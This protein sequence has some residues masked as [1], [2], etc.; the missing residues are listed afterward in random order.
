TPFLKPSD[1]IRGGKVFWSETGETL[2]ITYGDLGERN[3]YTYKVDAK[4][5]SAKKIYQEK[6]YFRGHWRDITPVSLSDE[7]ILF[8]SDKDG[9]YHLYTMNA[10]NGR[11]VKKLTKGEIY[12]RDIVGL[13]DDWIYFMASYIYREN[14]PYLYALHRIKTNGTDQQQVTQ[15]GVG[16]EVTPSPDLSHFLVEEM[17]LNSPNA[18]YVINQNG[19]VLEALT[20]PSFI[21]SEPVIE[22]VSAVTRDRRN[23]VWAS[24]HKPTD[25]DPSKS[26]PV[27]HH[28]HGTV[29]FYWSS[30][31]GAQRR[32]D[33]RQRIADLGFIVIAAD[34]MG[35]V[36]RTRRFLEAAHA[37]GH[38]WGGTLYIILLAKEIAKQRP[39][40]NM[41]KVGVH[42]LSQGGNCASRAIFEFPDDIHVSVSSA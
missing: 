15:P 28:V 24:V 14:D 37:A 36:G 23:P 6:G 38:Q 31:G 40:M 5:G 30:A 2:H 12:V 21:E 4:D 11:S 10:D 27:I 33:L 7:R 35:S 13:K 29:G 19:E 16:V 8:A 41:D 18:H 20:Q 22:R 1:P 34:G 26:Y 39:Y 3:L 25:F 9:Y 32:A 17:S 42:G